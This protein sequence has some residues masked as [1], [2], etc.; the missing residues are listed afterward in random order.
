MN[1]VLRASLLALGLG[2][3]QCVW[4][5]T[6]YVTVGTLQVLWTFNGGQSCNAAGV[7][8]VTVSI[9]G[10]T[11]NFYCYD[12][13]SG[14]QGATLYNVAAGTQP[15]RLTGFS[16]KQALYQWTGNLLV[17]GGAFNS[18]RQD[19]ALIGNPGTSNSNITF[20]WSFGGRTCNQAGVNGV[21]IAVQDPI[22]GNVNTIVP[23]TQLNVDGANVNNFAAGTY[24]FTLSV[25][26]GV[27][28][29]QYR[30]LGTATVN[31]M[32]S[33]TVNVDLQ[34]GYPPITGL[35]NATVGLV[36]SGQS[37]T[38][39][40]VTQILADLRDLNGNVVSSTTVSCS[41]FTGSVPFTQL[42]AAATY[43]LDAV[44]STT[45]ADGGMTVPYQLTGQ[46]LTIQPSSTSNYNLDVPPA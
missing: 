40:G 44:G 33:I 26:N 43:Y 32:S 11:F 7:T 10:S 2:L 38:R 16:G 6:P 45:A 25:L 31:G 8:T 34:P 39:A 15:V 22:G 42:N 20:L 24:P 27:G 4:Y 12:P 14:V 17:Y 29:T 35:G 37:C 1:A 3:T 36:F 30:A 13:I 41:S 18:Y 28:Q 5:T 23:C 9:S 19:L 21:N 46:G